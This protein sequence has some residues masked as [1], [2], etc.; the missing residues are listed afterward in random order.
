MLSFTI[1][2]MLNTTET[3]YV[4]GYFL[5]LL[6]ISN[7]ES[8]WKSGPAFTLG[9]NFNWCLPLGHCSLI[10]RF[11]DPPTLIFLKWKK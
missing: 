6:G 8:S 4:K 3:R 11:S 2:I 1:R 10:F 7:I 9:N 5:K